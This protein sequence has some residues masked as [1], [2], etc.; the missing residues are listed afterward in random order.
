MQR[1]A[2]AMVRAWDL[3]T[4]VFHWVLVALVV[5]A[6]V[7]Y[8]FTEEL[9]DPRLVWHRWNGLAV[10]V[11]LVWRVLWGI[12]GSSTSRFATFVRAPSAALQYARDL[13]VGRTRRFL[14]HNPLGALMVLVLLAA[15]LV[16]GGLG[17]FAVEDSELARGPLARLVSKTATK[18]ATRWHDW[19]FDWVVLTLVSVHVAANALYGIVKKEPLIPA[20]ITGLKPVADYEDAREATMPP[21]PLLRAV[22]CLLAAAALVFG[23]ILALGGRL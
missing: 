16:Q 7:S 18:A 19:M 20:M 2:E 14:G 3:P 22:V 10:L 6:W 4:R 15:L 1:A 11:L 21:R 9:G 5:S 23:T 12:A 8:E 13:A 17:L